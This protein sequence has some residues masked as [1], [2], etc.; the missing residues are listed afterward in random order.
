[1]DSNYK[2][3]GE[4]IEPITNRNTDL[5]YG[6]EDVRGISNTK[7]I[8]QTK[9]RMGYTDLKNFYVIKPG[10]FIFNPRTSRN[11]EKIGVV[12]NNTHQTYIFS[13]NNIGFK[14]KNTA[15]NKLFPEYL[16]LLFN[17]PEFDRYARYNSWG[18]A[19]ELFT[20]KDMC[21]TSF[22]LPSLEEQKKIVREYQVIEKRLEILNKFNENLE[23]YNVLYFQKQ[24]E[25]QKNNCNYLTLKNLCTIKGG[26]RL[27]QG[28]EL[29]VNPTKHPYIRVR[30][31]NNSIVTQLNS[32]YEYL[33]EDVYEKLKN[34][35]V[36]KNDIIISI[37][38]T[39]GLTAIVG[40]TLDGANLTE[41]C[42]KL[43]DFNNISPFYILLFL[44]TNDGKMAINNEIVGAVQ[45]KLPIKNVQEI[46]IPIIQEDNMNKINK[47]SA[48]IFS[49]ISNVQL[50]I[51]RLKVIQN[52]ILKSVY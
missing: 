12:Y 49:I 11:G 47:L 26:K 51:D 17:N 52:K 10:E 39:I 18:S 30:D 27:P 50:E 34:Y 4:Y 33:R 36:K 44:R 21:E 13:F 48:K 46:K 35:I 16:F 2:I 25:L 24:I 38:G 8:M 45:A 29:S 3:L 41:N 32:Q 23:K 19:T 7:E 31:L 40:D 6:E 43:T 42:V 37:V 9:A 22:N 15:L 1:M 20:W 14:I 5:T 28:R